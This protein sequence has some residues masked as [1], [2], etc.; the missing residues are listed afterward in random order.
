MW[1]KDKGT[2]AESRYVNILDPAEQA[3]DPVL[4]D[5]V[6]LLPAEMLAEA[7]KVTLTN[8]IAEN[9]PSVPGNRDRLIQLL[10]IF[11]DNAV[12]HS[13]VGASVHLTLDQNGPDRIRCI[14]Q[15]TGPGISPED[16]PFIWERFYKADKAHQRDSGGSGLGLAIA[17]QILRLHN[18]QFNV[19]SRPGEGTRIELEFPRAI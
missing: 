16:L 9:L 4:K 6:K 12:K 14:I 15:D 10:L 7:K 8:Q 1:S 18:A 2:S 17:R 3:R 13:P 19:D 5:A 11:L